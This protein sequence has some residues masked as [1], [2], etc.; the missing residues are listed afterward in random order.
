MELGSQKLTKYC[1]GTPAINK[2]V[3]NL[4]AALQK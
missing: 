3:G 2:P 1:C 4:T